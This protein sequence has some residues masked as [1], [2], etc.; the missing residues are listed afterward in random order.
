MKVSEAKE[1]VAYWFKQKRHCIEG[2]IV[3]KDSRYP[4]EYMKRYVMSLAN[5]ANKTKTQKSICNEVQSCSTLCDLLNVVDRVIKNGDKT[6]F[7]D[8]ANTYR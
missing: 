7:I 3:S 8:Y 6:E 5:K 2:P 1:C 4:L